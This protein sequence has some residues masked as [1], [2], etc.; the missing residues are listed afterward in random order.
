MFHSTERSASRYFLAGY[1]AFLRGT[2]L[3]LLV[4][5]LGTAGGAEPVNG[6]ASSD[7]A[8]SSPAPTPAQLDFFEQRVRP[9]LAS[10]CIQCHGAKRQRGELRLDSRAALLRGGDSGPAIEPGKPESSLLIAAV[11]HESLAMPPE[12][13]LTAAEIESLTHWIRDGAPWPVNQHTLLA[14]SRVGRGLT[15]EDRAWWAFQPLAAAIPPATTTPRWSLS[16]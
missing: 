15:A 9:I 13:R 4:C 12:G 6:A 3:L 1:Q 14:Q 11:K 16:P 5:G 2:A 7:G 8:D 10:Q